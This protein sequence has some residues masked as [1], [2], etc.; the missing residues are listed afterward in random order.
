MSVVTAFGPTSIRIVY[1]KGKFN[2][3]S[4]KNG[5]KRKQNNGFIPSLSSP[6]SQNIQQC[7]IHMVLHYTEYLKS[8]ET[9]MTSKD[10][11]S[12]SSLPSFNSSISKE[13]FNTDHRAAS[14]DSQKAFFCSL[15]GP[16][17]LQKFP[18]VLSKPYLRRTPSL[19]E[20]TRFLINKQ[21]K[22]WKNPQNVDTLPLSNGFS[23]LLTLYPY[24]V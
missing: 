5:K 24:P 13:S 4:E 6:S 14:D 22:L 15:L 2:F 3:D 18:L 23:N 16:D 9:K 19:C 20:H 17:G 11:L 12:S 10:T 7:V 1:S 21:I 8:D